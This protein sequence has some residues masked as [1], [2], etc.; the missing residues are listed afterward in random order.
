MAYPP[1]VFGV[2]YFNLFL[3]YFSKG[4]NIDC[5]AAV[6]VLTCFFV[7]TCSWSFTR[8]A[9]IYLC[10]CGEKAISSLWACGAVGCGNCEGLGPLLVIWGRCGGQSGLPISEKMPSQSFCCSPLIIQSG[11]SQLGFGAVP[12]FPEIPKN[13]DSKEHLDAAV[14]PSEVFNNLQYTELYNTTG[15]SHFRRVIFLI[16]YTFMGQDLHCH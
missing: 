8:T 7:V 15:F 11:E 1:D 3:L 9:W 4:E 12:L 10:W 13:L 14:T 16:T 6:T 2:T 5:K